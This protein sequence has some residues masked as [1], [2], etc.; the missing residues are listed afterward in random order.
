MTD[1]KN[2]LLANNNTIDEINKRVSSISNATEDI[3]KTCVIRITSDESFL[4]YINGFAD[5][6][7][8]NPYYPNSTSV[9]LTRALANGMFVIIPQE[10]TSHYYFTTEN[11]ELIHSTDTHWALK[12]PYQ[13][14]AVGIVTI[15]KI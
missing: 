2:R 13:R 3:N 5:N 10:S 15:D 1:Y 14:G 4:C 12:A 6:N 7:A 11:V 8:I 9:N